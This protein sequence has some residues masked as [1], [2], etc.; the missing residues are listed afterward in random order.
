MKFLFNRTSYVVSNSNELPPNLTKKSP[1][2]SHST[3]NPAFKLNAAPNASVKN[4]AGLKM[5]PKR[6]REIAQ[7]LSIDS[8]FLF[9]KTRT[10]EL[11]AQI[12]DQIRSGLTEQDTIPQGEVLV[13]TNTIPLATVETSDYGTQTAEFNCDECTERSQRVMINKHTQSTWKSCNIGVQ[14]NEKD[15][16]EPIV[17]LL[18][19]M[20]AAQLVA[21]KDFANI[22][23]E[24]RPQ[25]SVDMFKIRERLMDIY[26]LS[27]RDADAVR[28]AE[29]NRLDDIQYIE[30]IR[31]RSGD[32]YTEGSSRD[33][34]RRSGSPRI[35]NGN[36]RMETITFNNDRS[37]IDDRNIPPARLLDERFQRMDDDLFQPPLHPED[38]EELERQRYIEMERQRELELELTQRRYDEQM[39]RD[40]ERERRRLECLEQDRRQLAMQSNMSFPGPSNHSMQLDD[41]MR[42]FSRDPDDRDMQRQNNFNMG[43]GGTMNRRGRGAFRDNFRGRGRRN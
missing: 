21:L 5:L 27:Q 42:N 35:F 38:E 24:P 32:L 40:R 17:E 13:Q 11:T 26:N 30:Q 36:N 7:S 37:R 1:L 15:Y 43:R 10:K 20:T 31:F 8:T 3:M 16:R 23:D 39:E 34:E 9:E 2:Q 12:T 4:I 6:V 19:K 41:D 25:N 28:S 22:V 14:T 29:E 18:S 33:F